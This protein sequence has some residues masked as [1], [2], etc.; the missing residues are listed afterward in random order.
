MLFTAVNYVN[1]TDIITIH[2]FGCN[3]EMIATKVYHH[4]VC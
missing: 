4:N 1:Q 3:T 2:V